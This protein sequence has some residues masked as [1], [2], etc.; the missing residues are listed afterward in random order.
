[1]RSIKVLVAATVA[2]GGL[3]GPVHSASAVTSPTI[4]SLGVE[5]HV[6]PSP[7]TDTVIDWA[8][9]GAFGSNQMTVDLYSEALDETIS[10]TWST[11]GNSSGSDL[12][13][14]TLLGDGIYY[15]TRARLQTGAGSQISYQLYFDAPLLDDVWFANGVDAPSAPTA[16]VVTNDTMPG[17]EIGEIA[18]WCDPSDGH[19][20]P[21]LDYT[22]TATPVGGG[23]PTTLT[24]SGTRCSDVVSGLDPGLSY[25]LT[26][27]GRTGVGSSPTSNALT[28]VAL[29]GPPAAPT[30]VTAVTGDRSVDI[31]WSRPESYHQIVDAYA[32][33]VQCNGQHG[34]LVQTA[35][36]VEALTSTTIEGL[37]NGCAG[38]VRVTAH[39][40]KGW[41]VASDWI[42]FVPTSGQPPAV[43]TDVAASWTTDSAIHL[44]WAWTDLPVGDGPTDYEVELTRDGET[45]TTADA[46]CC[47]WTSD[48]GLDQN[49]VYA[50]RVRAH[51]SAGWSDWADAV[52]L[53][54]ANLPGAVADLQVLGRYWRGTA[55]WSP[56]V[57]GTAEGYRVSVAEG[58]EAGDCS[59][60]SEVPESPAPL[61]SLQPGVDYVVSVCA[62]NS[63]GESGPATSMLLA[64]TEV[65]TRSDIQ[66]AVP[67][68]PFTIQGRA[69]ATFDGTGI[70]GTTL[71]LQRRRA[72][73]FRSVG[74]EAFTGSRGRFTM[75]FIPR[76]NA[77]YR[78][79]LVHQA[80]LGG[81]AGAVFLGW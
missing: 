28:D 18:V 8:V 13:P 52:T 26:A 32:V 22:L 38:S 20:L 79:A 67:G 16:P 6:I 51:N 21:V 24:R 69:I 11:G 36:G 76:R 62:E 48:S 77:D 1:M 35:G 81:S 34:Y 72:S 27:V 64:G 10:V 65:R 45:P 12:V 5:T 55:T 80:G 14:R 56:P 41:G 43:P 29:A 71:T 68:E 4:T 58:R 46:S 7:N 49:H 15:A 75:E 47:S 66:P 53:G 50:I 40:T 42:T 9:A 3:L 57:T 19:G 37:T 60:G 39:S 30:D 23:A 31:S 25:D 54:G 17:P 70:A 59:L 61:E 78:L 74:V 33:E 2:V 63:I 44:S 73:G